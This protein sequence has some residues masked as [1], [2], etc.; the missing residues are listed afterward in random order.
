MGDMGLGGAD[1]DGV[2]T[3]VGC[4]DGDEV[5]FVLGLF[6]DE[7][8][9]VLDLDV[10]SVAGELPVTEDDFGAFSVVV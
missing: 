5:G 3:C 2:A 1:R 6:V 4:V 7:L 9:P 8:V 10:V